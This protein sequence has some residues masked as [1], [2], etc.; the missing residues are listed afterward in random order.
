VKFLLDHDVPDDI[1]FSLEALGHAVVKLREV[2]EAMWPGF[3]EEW[4]D[5]SSAYKFGSTRMPQLNS[6]DTKTRRLEDKA[7]PAISPKSEAFT[8]QV[9]PNP[10]Q[11]PPFPSSFFASS[12][13]RC[14]HPGTS[15]RGCSHLAGH[16]H[17]NLPTMI[18]VVRQTLIDLGSGDVGEAGGD[19]AV[20][21]LTVLERTDHVVDADARAFDD[22]V[23][24]TDSRLASNIAVPAA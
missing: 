14:S 21:G 15:R 24:A 18:L 11:H 13:L 17:V 12:R 6:E 23:A 16:Q 19:D 7:M 20:H 9:I 5:P 10:P 22:G 2:F 8:W 3:C 4:D 1:A